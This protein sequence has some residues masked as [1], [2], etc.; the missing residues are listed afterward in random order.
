MSRIVIKSS[1]DE[2]DSEVEFIELRH[3]P[4]REPLDMF[5]VK[6]NPLFIKVAAENLALNQLIE[7]RDLRIEELEEEAK[8]KDVHIKE[9]YEELHRQDEINLNH[10]LDDLA[11]VAK[12]IQTAIQN[13][14]E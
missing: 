10:E 2:E 12:A 8:A 7:E 14:K 11:P 9:L 1:S 4:A 5:Q 3:P 6:M 13:E